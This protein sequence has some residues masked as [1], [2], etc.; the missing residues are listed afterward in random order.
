MAQLSSLWRDLGLNLVRCRLIGSGLMWLSNQAC[1]CFMALQRAASFL[2]PGSSLD[3]AESQHL[4]VKTTETRGMSCLWALKP[5][6]LDIS[7]SIFSVCLWGVLQFL[8]CVC[9]FYV[10]M[11]AGILQV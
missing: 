3:L 8:M 1:C 10:Y 6:G 5:N 11:F 9:M 2:L 4:S 7:G